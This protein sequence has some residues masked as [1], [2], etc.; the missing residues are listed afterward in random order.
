MSTKKDGGPAYS[1]IQYPY[2]E[3]HITPDTIIEHWVM[4]RDVSRDGMIE[5]FEKFLKASGFNFGKGEYLD[6]KSGDDSAFASVPSS[7]CPSC[8]LNLHSLEKELLC[9]VRYI[10]DHGKDASGEASIEQRNEFIDHAHKI[11]N[12]I[13]EENV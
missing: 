7:E 12:L 4:D 5:V 11:L 8:K 3:P 2:D 1:F 13:G 6:V 10:A 9:Y